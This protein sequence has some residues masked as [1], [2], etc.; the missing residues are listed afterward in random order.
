MAG[1]AGGRSGLDRVAALF[2]FGVIVFN[3]P[4]LRVFGVGATVFGWPLLYVYILGVWGAV[5]V[6][7]ALHLERDGRGG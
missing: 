1:P 2:L 4:L 7:L 5:I 6:M 3:P